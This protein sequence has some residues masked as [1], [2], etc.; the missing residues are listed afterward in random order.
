MLCK[1]LDMSVELLRDRKLKRE[2]E[3]DKLTG[4]WLAARCDALCL[5]LAVIKEQVLK[6]TYS[7]QA[8]AALRKIKLVLVNYK[9][10]C[11]HKH[12]YWRVV[13]LYTVCYCIGEIY[14]SIH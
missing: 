13:S 10:K 3:K 12:L 1:S 5:K 9:S 2:R 4:D 14:L 11:L 7:P 8:V 6:E